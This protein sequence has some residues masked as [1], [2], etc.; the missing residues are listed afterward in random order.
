M[1]EF[2]VVMKKLWEGKPT[3]FRGEFY[4]LHN[5]VLTPGPVQKPH[6]PVWIASNA[7]L[8]LRVTA[9]VGDGWLPTTESVESYATKVKSLRKMA[10]EQGR[11]EDSVEPWLF[12][13]AV[14]SEDYDEARGRIREM[15]RLPLAW[16]SYKLNRM[17]FNISAPVLDITRFEVTEENLKAVEEATADVPLELVEKVTCFGTPDD[18]IKKLEQYYRAGLRHVVFAPH[19]NY[20][21]TT[22]LIGRR[23]VP[24]FLK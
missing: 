12:L 6:P 17:G 16:W 20:E 19:G 21:E 2:V 22:H 10:E 18:F 3:T 24:Y 4:N 9:E 7:P 8:S 23:V 15:I 11:S 13:Y 1:R 14:V 5:A